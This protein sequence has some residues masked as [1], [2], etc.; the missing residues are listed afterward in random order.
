MSS[1]DVQ[2][3]QVQAGGLLLA[4]VTLVLAA[5]FFMDVLVREMSEGPELMVRAPEARVLEPGAAVWISGVPGG[6][7]V[8]IRLLPPGAG[9][10]AAAGDQDV[11][12]RRSRGE[13]APGGERTAGTRLGEPVL[14]RAVLTEEAARTLR[15]DASARIQP[16]ALLSPPVLSIDPGRSAG[17][18][19]DF[20][21]TLRARP[22]ASR[23]EVTAAADSL[24]HRLTAL[25]PLVLRLQD[26]ITDGPGTVAAL[27]RDGETRRS[28]RRQLDALAQL[29]READQESAA[30]L[31]RDTLLRAR[32]HRIAARVSDL[33]PGDTGAEIRRLAAELGELR[34]RLRQLESRVDAGR[35]SVGRW[36]RDEALDRE[37]R[38]LRISLEELPGVLL[39]SPG[40][41]LRIGLF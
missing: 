20:S 6:R 38:K 18:S 24:A 11:P 9:S 30:R 13:A 27:L 41:W 7:V 33:E 21:D 26:R 28:L 5:I 12:K 17:A 29:A 40:R 19:F 31:A 32:L 14:I 36:L 23:R 25:Q 16:A 1:R 3:K 10:P 22:T 37:L 8:S 2:W 39:R 34:S 35:G 4:A 15:A